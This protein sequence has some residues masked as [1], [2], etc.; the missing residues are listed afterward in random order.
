MEKSTDLKE[1]TEITSKDTTSFHSSPKRLESHT[2]N[3]TSL[4]HVQD[5]QS[6]VHSSAVPPVPLNDLNTEET[7]NIDSI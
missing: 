6:T 4:S 5:D 3:E 2:S 1:S 7:C